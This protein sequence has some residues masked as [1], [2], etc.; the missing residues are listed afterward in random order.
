[1]FKDIPQTCVRQ[2][3]FTLWQPV[4]QARWTCLTNL[5]SKDIPLTCAWQLTSLCWSQFDRHLC[6][7]QI[8]SLKTS[9]GN[10]PVRQ[11]SPCGNLSGRHLNVPDK[12]KVSGNPLDMCLVPGGQSA[13][14]SCLPSCKRMPRTCRTG[15]LAGLFEGKT[16]LLTMLS[17]SQLM[18]SKWSPNLNHSCANI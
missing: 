7:W 1:M 5:K 8:W 11:T 17:L 3:Y 18:L 4:W 6:A 14:H 13:R 16:I 10:V 9:P 2:S 15:E 12:S